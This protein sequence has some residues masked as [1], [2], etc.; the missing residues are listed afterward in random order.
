[1]KRYYSHYAFI[2]PNIYLKSYIV[3]VDDS[4][5][6]TNAFPFSRE[7]EK[8]E[9]YSGL[10]I[11]HPEGIEVNLRDRVKSDLFVNSN[12]SLEFACKKYN[13]TH[14]EDLTSYIY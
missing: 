12:K 10:L 3:E 8:T 7:I 13:I 11:F 2:Y 4:G 9:F 6:I 5:Q 14:I 1:M